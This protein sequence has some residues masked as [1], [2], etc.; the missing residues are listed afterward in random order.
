[1]FPVGLSLRGRTSK[2]AWTGRLKRL[3]AILLL[4]SVA[5]AAVTAIFGRPAMAAL[6]VMMLFPA[7]CELGVRSAVPLE[8]RLSQRFVDQASEALQPDRPNRRGDHR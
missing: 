5:V 7:L 6:V 8:H 3:A 1:M 4:A 2:L